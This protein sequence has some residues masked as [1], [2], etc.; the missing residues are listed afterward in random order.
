[1]PKLQS[2]LLILSALLF[3]SLL[4]AKPLAIFTNEQNNCLNMHVVFNTSAG[5]L[6]QTGKIAGFHADFLNALEKKTGICINKKLLPY[7][8]AKRSIVLG[9]HDG[10]ILASSTDL[11]NKVIYVAKL[12]ISKTI[13]IP[14]KGLTLNNYNDLSNIIIG[15]VRGAK[16]DEKVDN[17]ENILFVE[18]SNYQHGLEMLKKGRIDAIAGNNLGL[19]VIHELNMVED[20]N[21]SGKFVLGQREVWFL[22]SNT[23]QHLD[24]IEQLREATLALVNEKVVEKILQKY[25]GK[26][27]DLSRE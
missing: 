10:G 19:T 6:N 3:T 25:F 9:G 23:S 2:I 20:V 17:D 7:A 1:M 16:L 11:D 14:K 22:L 21:L 13:V 27:L 18:L 12:L 8:R 4:S 26:S 24:K 5:Y 15:K